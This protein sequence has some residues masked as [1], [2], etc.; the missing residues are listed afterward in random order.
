MFNRVGLKNKHLI[1]CFSELW[2]SW[3]TLSVH[4]GTCEQPGFTVTPQHCPFPRGFAKGYLRCKVRTQTHSPGELPAASTRTEQSPAAGGAGLC[5]QS[6]GRGPGAQPHLRLCPAGRSFCAA[7]W[8][9]PQT[10]CRLSFPKCSLNREL[11][12]YSSDLSR[13]VWLIICFCYITLEFSAQT[14]F[15]GLQSKI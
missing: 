13:H 10:P 15:W 8:R 14:F 9:L 7:Q 2:P 11:L 1:N 3:S 12:V 4:A 5:E 6:S